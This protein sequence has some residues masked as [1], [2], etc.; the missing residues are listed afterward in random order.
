M[1]KRFGSLFA[2][3]IDLPDMGFDATPANERSYSNDKLVTVFDKIDLMCRPVLH[4][5]GIVGIFLVPV[6]T[7]NFMHF[8]V[9][10]SAEHDI[11]LLVS[12]AQGQYRHAL[13]KCAF[14]Q[15]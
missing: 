3:H 11:Q 13:F 15:R 10:G 1:I 6:I 5:Q 9:Q 7:G 12:P 2:G 4:I 14:R 8:L